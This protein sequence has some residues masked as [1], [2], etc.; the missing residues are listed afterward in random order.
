MAQFGR[1]DQPEA[2]TLASVLLPKITKLAL[3]IH[4][5]SGQQ[6]SLAFLRMLIPSAL[7][8]EKFFLRA[9]FMFGSAR[10]VELNSDGMKALAEF[11]KLR[12]L[13]EVVTKY[14]NFSEVGFGPWTEF[15]E[16]LARPSNTVSY[17]QFLHSFK[18]GDHRFFGDCLS[19]SQV[20]FLWGWLVGGSAK[21][22]SPP[23]RAFWRARLEK[24]K[25]RIRDRV[26]ETE[27]NTSSGEDGAEEE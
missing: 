8:V 7:S 25:Q 14:V 16:Q 27:E 15:F 1:Q 4:P 6:E 12:T 9:S 3:F 13:R 20:S 11:C 19:V 23:C 10:Y 5:K 17:L 18:R 24:N 22:L 21:S 26:K 2:V